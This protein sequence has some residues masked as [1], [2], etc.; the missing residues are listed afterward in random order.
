MLLINTPSVT[1]DAGDH[2]A[3]T[4]L[5]SHRPA[6]PPFVLIM[7]SFV[8]CWLVVCQLWVNIGRYGSVLPVVGFAFSGI[9]QHLLWA[10]VKQWIDISCYGFPCLLWAL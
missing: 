8:Q 2:D 1:S 10:R 7:P 9:L 5:A 6:V 4:A 3:S